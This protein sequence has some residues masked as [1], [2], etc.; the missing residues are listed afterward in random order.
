MIRKRVV[1]LL[2]AGASYGYGYPSGADLKAALSSIDAEKMALMNAAGFKQ[3]QVHDFQRR[4]AASGLNSVDAFLLRNPSTVGIAKIRIA[5]ELAMAERR[6]AEGNGVRPWGRETW[7]QYLFSQFMD[8]GDLAAFGNNRCSFV[9]LNYDRSL[10]YALTSMLSNAYGTTWERCAAIVA[11]IPIVHLHGSPGPLPGFVRGETGIAYGE[12]GDDPS[13]KRSAAS[14]LTLGEAGSE[15][16]YAL[17]SELLEGADVIFSLGFGYHTE[18]ISRL[19]LACD[20][21]PE[22]HGTC[23]GHTQSEVYAVAARF[24]PR[25]FEEVRRESNLRGDG[26]AVD[27]IRASVQ[28][29]QG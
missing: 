11:E 25:R 10:E 12:I 2:G 18:V 3:E 21:R 27:Y 29:F 6:D 20:L 7:Y 17:A 24:L 4:L 15:A 9:T 1:F 22:I 13:I 8:D 5:Q 19:K 23:Q 16:Q 26:P 14:I 28:L